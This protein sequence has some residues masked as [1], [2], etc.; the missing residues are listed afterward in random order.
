VRHFLFSAKKKNFLSEEQELFGG[1]IS[2]EP[3]RR[4]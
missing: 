1:I 4:Y 3:G 2:G